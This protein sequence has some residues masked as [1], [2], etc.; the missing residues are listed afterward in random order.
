MWNVSLYYLG[1]RRV[2]GIEKLKKHS[3]LPPVFTTGGK[4]FIVYDSYN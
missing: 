2:S 4:F 3:V 1:F